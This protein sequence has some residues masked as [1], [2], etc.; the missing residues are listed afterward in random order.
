M[1]KCNVLRDLNALIS[2]AK[3]FSQLG[4][5]LGIREGR[6]KNISKVRESRVLWFIAS[7]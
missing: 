1:D 4:G 6:A 5:V 3:Y 2:E 7:T